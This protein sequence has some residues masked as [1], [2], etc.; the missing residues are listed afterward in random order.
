M[1]NDP[2]FSDDNGSGGVS[3]NPDF[4]RNLQNFGFATMA[5]GGQP[6]ATTLGAIGQGGVAA[7]D[8]A[9]T[10]AQARTQQQLTG[11]EISSKNMGNALSLQQINLQRQAMGMPPLRVPGVTDML[12]QQQSPQS[13]PDQQNSQGAPTM[14]GGTPPPNSTGLSSSPTAGMS[15]PKASFREQPNGNVQSMPNPYQQNPQRLLQIGAGQLEPSSPQEAGAAAFWAHSMGNDERAKQLNTY[16][17]A[18]PIA[19]SEAWAR[20][21]PQIATAGGSARAELPYKEKE[22]SMKPSDL[23]GPGSARIDPYTNSI[24]QIPNEINVVDPKTLQE[25]KTFVPLGTITTPINPSKPMGG[26]NSPQG[27]QVPLLGEGGG[28]PASSAP[29]PT[30]PM[31]SVAPAQIPSAPGTVGEKTY[32]TKAGPGMEAL[33]KGEAE[34]FDKETKA[35]NA[36]QETLGHVATMEPLFDQLNQSGWSSTGAGAQARQGLAKNINGMETALGVAPGSLSFDPTKVAS[37]E[38]L[39]KETNRMGMTLI[40]Q[41]FGA[42]REAASTITTGIK[43]VPGTENTMQGAKMMLNGIKE[44]AQYQSDLYNYKLQWAQDH[45]GNLLGAD[46]QFNKESGGPAKYG[47]RAISQTIPYKVNSPKSLSLYLPGTKVV[48]P[49]GTPMVVQ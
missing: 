41:N 13:S 1:A 44:S 12:T 16:A 28:S 48:A 46:A 33:V 21:N 29:A 43:S 17:L 26:M 25:N 14:G 39:Y 38:D 32:M 31:S 15:V 4:W 37:A 27:G 8:S 47:K 36:A 30:G 9:R 40:Q 19:G 24:T 18:G 3:Q 22:N 6:G 49:D 5:A 20:V 34:N 7:M 10:N 45:G 42:A 11:A 23:R 35:Y 2:F